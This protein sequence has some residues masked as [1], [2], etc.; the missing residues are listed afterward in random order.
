MAQITKTVVLAAWVLVGFT[1]LMNY[2]ASGLAAR[3]NI[4][5]A[6]SD[7]ADIYTENCAKCHGDDGRARTAKGKRVGARDFTNKD[8]NPDEER[9]IRI[10]TKGKGQM[11]SFKG[12]LSTDEI[13]AVFGY[14]LK[15]RQ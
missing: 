4:E 15:F 3:S 14:V 13:K 10:I 5:A 2:S 1:C 6:S 9:D 7:P 12:E 11:P 8:W